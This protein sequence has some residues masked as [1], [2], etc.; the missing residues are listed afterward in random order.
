[1][2]IRSNY[3]YSEMFSKNRNRNRI[4]DSIPI[5][6][7]HEFPSKTFGI[8]DS[9]ESESE[10]NHRFH[11]HMS[12]LLVKRC[13]ICKQK[14]SK[15]V[16]HMYIPTS[17]IYFDNQARELKS[18]FCSFVESWLPQ[19]FGI[20]YRAYMLMKAIHRGF[21]GY[22]GLIVRYA[23][24]CHLCQYLSLDNQVIKSNRYNKG[25]SYLSF[26]FSI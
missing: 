21:H 14:M 24:I 8:G 6:F 11:F 7:S 23:M 17:N 3:P 10:Q 25:N 1:M 5:L 20:D 13:N 16:L 4:T 12:R 22:W 15:Y 9:L 26:K 19:K 18:G 2:L